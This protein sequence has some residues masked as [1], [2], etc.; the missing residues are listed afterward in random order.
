M[1]DS[2]PKTEGAFEMLDDWCVCKGVCMEPWVSA[3]SGM[4]VLQK[5]NLFELQTLSVELP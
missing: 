4:C 5:Q 1:S 3:D 2:L